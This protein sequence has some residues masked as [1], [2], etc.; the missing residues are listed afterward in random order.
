MSTPN[1]IRLGCADFTWPLLPHRDALSLIHLL[2][3]QGVDLG[4][5]F[6]RSHLRPENVQEDTSYWAGLVRERLDQAQLEV[7]DLYFAPS[8]DLATR[9]ANNP[10]LAEV[11]AGHEMFLS[12][13]DFARRI[14]APGITMNSG[15]DYGDESR[16]QSLS[17]S[18]SELARRVDAAGQYGIE[19]RVEGSVGSN[20]DNPESLGE[21]MVSTP[22]LRVTL[23]YS[24]F[25][26]QGRQE[27]EADC[28]IEYT[29][30][31][32]CR[33]AAPGV[34]Q[35][36]YEENTIDFPRII[37]GL[38]DSDYAGYFSLEYVWVD[39][40]GCNQTE[41]TMETVQFRDLAIATLEGR[42][43]TPVV[44]PQYDI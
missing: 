11:E 22:G 27:S 30:H 19:I 33:G 40:W 42:E 38:Q 8:M 4:M 39:I 9:G 29:G 13:L 14:Q 32:Q 5:F 18:A 1:T 36:R 6:E 3:F 44:G 2:G 34:M 21:L 12:V 20:T 23:D 28:L 24:H 17:R 31:F 26:Y 16:S 25:V 41:N 7:A 43:Y 10:D 15:M 35:A 37:Q